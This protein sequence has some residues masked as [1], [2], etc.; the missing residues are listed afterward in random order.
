MKH[1]IVIGGGVAGM[2]AAITAAKAGA[3]VTILESA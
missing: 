2:S 1:I 3:D